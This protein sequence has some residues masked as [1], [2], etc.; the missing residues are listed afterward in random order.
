MST[1]LTDRISNLETLISGLTHR[2]QQIIGQIEILFAK[3]DQ[4]ESERFE[5]FLDLDETCRYLH[6]SASTIRLRRR[7]GEF[8]EPCQRPQQKLLWKKTDLH[9]WMVGGGS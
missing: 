8:P 2:N 5:D 1:S 4:S 9:D 3:I 7:R 6:L